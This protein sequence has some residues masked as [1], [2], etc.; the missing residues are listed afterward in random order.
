LDNGVS[1]ILEIEL[2]R[3]DEVHQRIGQP[4]ERVLEEGF[5]LASDVGGV[6]HE[7]LHATFRT[8]SPVALASE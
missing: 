5:G 6:V 1:E 7:L 4:V 8:Q 3:G 2:A